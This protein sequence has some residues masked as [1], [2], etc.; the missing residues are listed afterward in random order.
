MHPKYLHCELRPNRGMVTTDVY[1]K[2]R[3]GQWLIQPCNRRSTS[4]TEFTETCSL[5]IKMPTL[6]PYPKIFMAHYG[7][8][9]SAEWLLLRSY[10][11]LPMPYPIPPLPTIQFPTKP[12]QRYQ[13]IK[14]YVQSDILTTARFL[15]VFE[16]GTRN[17]QSD[18]Q[19][20]E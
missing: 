14:Q 13:F 5:K 18:V 9:E 20:D 7:Q 15:V 17:G 2:L 19:A 11:H 3:T 4:Y 1:K 8:T 10:R 12:R 16:L 6:D